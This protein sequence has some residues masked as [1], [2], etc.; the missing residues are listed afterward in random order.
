MI[1]RMDFDTLMKVADYPPPSLFDDARYKSD[2]TPC[3]MD[4]RASTTGFLHIN[5]FISLFS[6]YTCMQLGFTVANVYI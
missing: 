6:S 3:C 5:L 2:V 1:R 4:T